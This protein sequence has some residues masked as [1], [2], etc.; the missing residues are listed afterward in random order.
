MSMNPQAF[1]DL[2]LTSID[3]AL[4]KLFDES[5]ARAVR[6]YI[7]PKIALRDSTS[8]A[9]VVQKMFGPGA[10]VILD[11]IISSVSSSAGLT[12]R[13]WSSLNECV[14]EVRK[15]FAAGKPLPSV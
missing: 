6:F 3:R 11:A 5:T 7:D 10:G 15:K 4:S 2:L 8:Y 14:G 13:T 1:D 9:R 12:G